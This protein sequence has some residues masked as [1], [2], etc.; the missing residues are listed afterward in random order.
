MMP[1][2]LYTMVIQWYNR[3]VKITRFVKHMVSS[4]N[5]MEDTFSCLSVG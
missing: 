2:P 5:Q 1:N 4:I 3:M